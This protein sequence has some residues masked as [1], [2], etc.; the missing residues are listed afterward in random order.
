MTLSIEKAL[1]TLG[2]KNGFN[3]DNPPKM[4]LIQKRFYQLS[5]LH[6]PDRPGGDNLVQQK[7]AEAYKLIG[8]YIEK[9]FDA[10]D[11]SEE[12]AARQVY[13]DFNFKNVKENLFS[14]TI[15]IDNDHSFFWESVLTK[16]YGPPIDRNTNGKHWK[17]KSYTDDNSNTGDISIGKW[18]IPKKDKQSKVLIQCNVSTNFLTAHFVS[19]HFPKL[20]AEVKELAATKSIDSNSPPYP[21]KKCDYKTNTKSQLQSH[22]KR[23]HKNPGALTIVSKTSSQIPAPFNVLPPTPT[24]PEPF[25]CYICPN[26]FYNQGEWDAHAKIAHDFKCDFCNEPFLTKSYL[27]EHLESTHVLSPLK[28]HPTMKC[29]HCPYSA[30]L[31]RSLKTHMKKHHFFKCTLCE[32]TFT[33]KDDLEHHLKSNHANNQAIVNLNLLKQLSC[34][35]CIYKTYHKEALD[36]H[37]KEM[38]ALPVKNSTFHCEFCPFSTTTRTKLLQHNTT[39]HAH[40]SLKCDQCAF[41]STS[42]FALDLHVVNKH[43]PTQDSQLNQSEGSIQIREELCSPINQQ[44]FSTHTC[45]LCGITF[46]LQQDLDS[47]IHRRHPPHH[48][49]SN[50]LDSPHQSKNHHLSLLLEEQMDM[51]QTLKQIK[52]SFDAQLN[53][54][55]EGQ[56]AI[57]ANQDA[58][59]EAIKQISDDNA[60]YH[61]NTASKF[62]SLQEDIQKQISI[63]SSS[64]SSPTTMSPTPSA[65][66]AYQPATSSTTHI[67]PAA[68]QVHTTIASAV[69]TLRSDTPKTSTTP[70][71][72]TTIKSSRLETSKRPKVLF[73][74]DSIGSNADIRHLEEATNSL[75]Y[76][77][78]AYGATYKVDALFPNKN[79]SAAAMNAPSK[80]P[81]SY[82]ILQGSSTDITNLDTSAGDS[83]IE[84]LKQEVAI[85]S[86]NMISAAKTILH[87]NKNIKKVLVLT[88]TPRFDPH[89]VDPHNLKG[90]LSE[91]GNLVLKEELDKSDMKN[92]IFLG[93]HTLPQHFQDNLYGQ[94]HDHRFDGIHLNGPDGRNHYTRSLCNILQHFLFEYSRESHNHIIPPLSKP[95]APTNPPTAG[96]SLPSSRSTSASSSQ[97]RRKPDTV[98]IDIES[99]P[100]FEDQLPVYSIPTFN[101][102]SI[103]GN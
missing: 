59:K 46:P 11:D 13:K 50:T 95:P 33:S 22:M 54:L 27:E 90:K 102:F 71:T 100:F 17:H 2:I 35:D 9:N 84:F 34:N 56:T 49:L 60:I 39:T 15:K 94:P 43:D 88:R 73:I 87:R 3:S 74:A 69:S 21:C 29:D 78:K 68:I 48:D 45:S 14:F 81:Y 37:I 36:T 55:R 24:V 93:I 8:E 91:Y 85:A 66:P 40:A 101:P 97:A 52:D 103:L 5:L 44:E 86:K 31:N 58:L 32:S 64:L 20:L 57:Q 63:L 80:R 16:H 38:H 7:I 89:S 10:K 41:I 65:T 76:T 67:N 99:F 98:I 18:H 19:E 96:L 83:N 70:S 79:F 23:V 77:E 53:I 6:H 12:E 4:K 30:T 82:A 25:K 92:Q 72:Y 62:N 26:A 42:Q 28:S 51:A 47:H 75:I 61:T 1:A